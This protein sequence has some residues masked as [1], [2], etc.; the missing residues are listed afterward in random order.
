MLESNICR[1]L[2]ENKSLAAIL[3]L[4]LLCDLT[5]NLQIMCAIITVVTCQGSLLWD[6]IDLLC[7][8]NT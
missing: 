2:Y 3:M 1:I 5:V 6:R 4:N 7:V 8:L